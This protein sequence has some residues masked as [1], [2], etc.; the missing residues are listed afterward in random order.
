[1]KFHGLIPMLYTELLGF[2][3][4]AQNEDENWA[5]LSKDEVKLMLAK[6]NEHIDFTEPIFSGSFYIKTTQVDALWQ[7]VKD[8]VEI[9]YPIDNFGWNMR[10]F[11]IYDNNGYVLQFGEEQKLN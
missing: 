2:T 7:L 10:E 3:C 5:T 8:K 11:G 9:C 4:D 6:P 1:M